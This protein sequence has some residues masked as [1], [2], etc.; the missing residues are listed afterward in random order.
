MGNIFKDKSKPIIIAGPCS[1]ESRLQLA[2]SV[3][4]LAALDEID[5]VR[6]G[7]WKPRTHPGG[8][9]GLGEPALAWMEEIHKSRPK[10]QFCCEVA[11]P[12][13]IELC[14]R[15][16]VNCVWIGARTSGDPFSMEQLAQALWGSGMSVMVKNPLT[17]EVQLWM[18]AI[19]RLMRA[20]IEDIAAIHRGF[21][22]FQGNTPYRNSPLWEIPIEL[23]RRMP[24][25]P[26]L[27]D[28]SH[29][30]GRREYLHTLMQ[31]AS[32]LGT[33]GFMV[34][35]HPHPAEALT[36]KEQQVTAAELQ[37]ILRH[38]VRRNN[39]KTSNSELEALRRNID[40]IDDTLLKKLKERMQISKQIATIKAECNMSV[41]QPKRWD[42]VLQQRI[43][44][45]TAMGLDG[46]F[47]KAIY[48][49]IHAE[50]VRIQEDAIEDN[51]NRLS[52]H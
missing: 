38:I 23:R 34:E 47:V 18:G 21:F 36:D 3:E 15:Y 13:H 6:C 52:S 9:E 4:S 51:P 28:P 37:Q 49:K 22:V 30:G 2:E 46:N 43:A 41:F 1:V 14:Q 16:G 26:I 40:L 8:F 44:N 11:R 33:D 25:L 19:E 17:A 48:E 31:T 42:E 12:E 27:C 29:I 35:V 24:E 39:E 50:S 20:G 10:I 7:V 32:D 45:A 5:M